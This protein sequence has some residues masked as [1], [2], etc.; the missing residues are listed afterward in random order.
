[1]SAIATDNKALARRFFAE[2]DKKSFEAAKEIIAPNFRS[3]LPGLPQ[4]LDFAGFE[5]FVSPFNASFPDYTHRIEDQ[6][7]EGDRVV[8]RFTWRGTHTEPFQGLPA[9]GRAVSMTGLNIIRIVD[10]KIAEQWVMFD[11]LGLMQQLG[12]IPT[13]E[14]VA[15]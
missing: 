12:A 14:P 7:A 13:P 6:V 3:H 9:T 2:A 5:Q 1:M 10:G 11:A 15:G 4:P 8:T